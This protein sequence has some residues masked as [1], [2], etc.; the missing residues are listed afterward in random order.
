MKPADAARSTTNVAATGATT[1]RMRFA[2][3]RK[4]N[5]P[6]RTVNARPSTVRKK[7]QPNAVRKGVDDTNASSTSRRA[8]TTITASTNSGKSTKHMIGCSKKNEKQQ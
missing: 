1:H 5:E 4:R 8:E 2:T 7:R 3:A 6:I